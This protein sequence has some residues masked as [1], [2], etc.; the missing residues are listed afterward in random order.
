MDYIPSQ[1]YPTDEKIKESLEQSR[2]LCE[3]ISTS[4]MYAGHYTQH[5][6]QHLLNARKNVLELLWEIDKRLED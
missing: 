4:I 2:I 1:Q 3:Q 6:G 5:C